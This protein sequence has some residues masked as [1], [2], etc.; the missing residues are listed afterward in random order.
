M[1]TTIRSK[2]F[3]GISSNQDLRKQGTTNV[4]VLETC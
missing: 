2:I 1:H 3:A 4:Q